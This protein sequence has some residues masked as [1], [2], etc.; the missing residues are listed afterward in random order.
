M[1][2]DDACPCTSSRSFD[3][4]CGPV[5]DDVKTA[6]TAEALMRARY[7]AHA[8]ER[9][10]F[11]EESLH[12]KQRSDHD[13]AAARR[14]SRKSDWEGLEVVATRGG[15]PESEEGQVEF[16]ARYRQEGQRHEH[17]EVSNFVREKGRWWLVGGRAPTTETVRRDGPM[18]GRN[19]PCPCGS[20]KKY[21]KCCA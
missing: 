12:P 19:D 4:C 9:I 16:I 20:G 18:V 2:G 21:K 7:T 17:H 14:W 8:V 5:L 13:A 10:E 1:K 11:L 15:G 3:D 6:A